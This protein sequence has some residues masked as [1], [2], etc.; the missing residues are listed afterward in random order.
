MRA[1]CIVP[2]LLAN[3][4][5]REIRSFLCFS[6]LVWSRSGHVAITLLL[7]APE[8]RGQETVTAPVACSVVDAREYAIDSKGKLV[9][10]RT[11]CMR[12]SAYY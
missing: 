8:D 7:H 6:I 9:I 4:P 1:S 3:D 12:V 11:L 10:C 2:I 5:V